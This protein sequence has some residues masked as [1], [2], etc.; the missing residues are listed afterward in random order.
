MPKGLRILHLSLG[1]MQ[2]DFVC[3]DLS[4]F[5]FLQ[6]AAIEMVFAKRGLYFQM[7]QLFVHCLYFDSSNLSLKVRPD[8]QCQRNK[9]IPNFNRFAN[10]FRKWL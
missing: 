6:K 8:L 10:F 5:S 4:C 2:P 1:E 9:P 3:G 7:F